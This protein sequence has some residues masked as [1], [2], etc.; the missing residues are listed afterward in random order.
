[1]TARKAFIERREY[2]RFQ[3]KEGVVALPVESAIRFG[4][5]KNIS[6]DGLSVLHFDGEDWEGRASGPDMTL[7]G[8]DFLLDGVPAE[9]VSDREVTINNP[10]KKISER[11][12][13]MKFGELTPKQRSRLQN[14]I[15]TQSRNGELT[16]RIPGYSF[17]PADS[18]E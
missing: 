12:C 3:L 14:I 15:R 10:Y 9:I 4:K 7:A 16:I 11:Q 6:M 18:T 8:Y 17:R 13:S 5:I 2:E 1:M